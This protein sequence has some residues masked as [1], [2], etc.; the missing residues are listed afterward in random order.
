MFILWLQKQMFETLLCDD[1]LGK[2]S[3]GKSFPTKS[4]FKS[5]NQQRHWMRYSKG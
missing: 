4:N 5:E 3:T 2:K 1:E